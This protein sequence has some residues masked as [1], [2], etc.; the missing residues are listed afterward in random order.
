MQI[1]FSTDV[2]RQLYGFKSVFNDSNEC[3]AEWRDRMIFR[4]HVVRLDL[5]SGASRYTHLSIYWLYEYIYVYTRHLNCYCCG[6]VIFTVQ[7]YW[8]HRGCLNDEGANVVM[9]TQ[10]LT[11]HVE[12]WWTW[13]LLLRNVC[14]CTS[15]IIL[16]IYMCILRYTHCDVVVFHAAVLLPSQWTLYRQLSDVLQNF[17]I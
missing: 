14:K 1:T 3:L 15:C 10:E 9:F 8:S 2:N 6:H 5:S 16:C 11:V 4:R 17:N 12:C 7:Y 13:L